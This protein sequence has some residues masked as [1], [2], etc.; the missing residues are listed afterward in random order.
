MAGVDP[1]ASGALVILDYEGGIVQAKP[2][3]KGHSAQALYTL[4]RE[5]PDLRVFIERSQAMPGQGVSSTF[6]YGRSFGWIE[7]IVCAVGIAPTFVCPR[8]WMKGLVAGGMERP[9]RKRALAEIAVKH[10]GLNKFLVGPRSV[11]PHQGLVD[12]SLIAKFGLLMQEK[13]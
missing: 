5:Y 6:T 10:W 3:D 2:F 12:A 13:K 4:I 1:G 7:G 11:K 8:I 9:D